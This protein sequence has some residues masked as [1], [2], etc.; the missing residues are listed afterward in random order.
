MNDFLI[1]LTGRVT[2][3][4]DTRDLISQPFSSIQHVPSHYPQVA[5]EGGRFGVLRYG[6]LRIIALVGGR[7]KSRTQVSL[8][9]GLP[10]CTALRW[11]GRQDKGLCHSLLREELLGQQVR[12]GV[13]QHSQ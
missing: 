10:D 8:G 2:G 11:G 9:P 7:A 1:Y 5:S 12:G 13:A 6:L 4:R 3:W